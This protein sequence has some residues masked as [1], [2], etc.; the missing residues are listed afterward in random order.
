[1]PAGMWQMFDRLVAYFPAET[2]ARSHGETISYLLRCERGDTS[3]WLDWE[4]AKH[5]RLLQRP[6]G[7]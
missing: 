5:A 1:M 4:Q 3:H 7:G 6:S 2:L